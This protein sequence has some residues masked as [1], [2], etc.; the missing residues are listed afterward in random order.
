MPFVSGPKERKSR[1]LGENLFLK[2]ERSSSQKS[3]MTRRP[4]P[5]GMHGKR[6]KNLSEYGVQLKEKQKLRLFFGLQEK[7]MKRYAQTAKNSKKTSAPEALFRLLESRID[8]AIFQSG[9]APSRSVARQMVTHGHLGLNGRRVNVPSIALKIGDEVSVV[10]SSKAKKIFSTK[11]E[12]EI[13]DRLKKH[14]PPTWIETDKDKL[15]FKFKAFPSLEE[16]KFN[17]NI[18]LVVE[19]YSR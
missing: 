16:A 17:F 15:S 18:P 13:Q 3:G 7:Q 6:R 19:Y 11:G 9:L 2:A 4:Y 8:S 10:E 14:E 5:P 1:A 12:E